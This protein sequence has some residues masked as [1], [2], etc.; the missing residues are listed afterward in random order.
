MELTVT[1][2]EKLKDK[3]DESNLGFGTLSNP[4]LP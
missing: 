1:E 4:T 3:P 2:A